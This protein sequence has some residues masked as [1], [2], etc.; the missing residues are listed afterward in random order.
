MLE[1]SPLFWARTRARLDPKQ[2]LAELGPIT[3]P[4]PPL[5]TS[6]ATEQQTAAE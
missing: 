1:L 6:C 4:Q 5:D 3:I 2:L